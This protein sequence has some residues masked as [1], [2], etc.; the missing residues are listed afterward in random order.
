MG[1][2]TRDVRTRILALGLVPGPSESER[3]FRASRTAE[4]L[5]QL[6]VNREANK[7]PMRGRDGGQISSNP[8]DKR[9]KRST[10]PQDPVTHGL[11]G[12]S[13][14]RDSSELPTRASIRK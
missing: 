8:R 13:P 1:Y 12:G 10:D 3:L 4:Y 2:L 7:K 14:C 5:R 6:S 11:H 9:P